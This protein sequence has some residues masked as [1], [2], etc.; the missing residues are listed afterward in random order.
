[1]ELTVK[2]IRNNSLFAK[3]IGVSKW[4]NC[5]EYIAP[6]WTRTGNIY[7]G[8]TKELQAE[9]EQALRYEPGYLAPTS[10]YWTTFAIKVGRDG[11]RFSTDNPLGLLMYNFLKDHKRVAYGIDKVRPSTD[12]LLINENTEAEQMNKRNK[13]RREAYRSFDK[14]SIE[15]MRKCLR[16]F[17]M[18]SDNLSNELVE[19]KLAEIIEGNA[20]LY[21]T[22]WVE[23]KDRDI[24]YMVETAIAK[25]IIRKNK[26][27]YYYGTDVIGNGIDDV[28][29]FFKDKTNQDIKLS[30]LNDIEVK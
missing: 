6:Y 16:L 20:Q 22:K 4:A 2:I 3:N 21:L 23:N 9:L 8:L 25:N 10:D 29:A 7:T 17:G 11:F 1:M 14:M 28:V 26:S 30:I 19:S 18:K 13:I 12:Y 15:E 27:L 24:Y 5:F